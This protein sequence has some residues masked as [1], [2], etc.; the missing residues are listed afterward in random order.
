MY[1]TNKYK[2]E[3]FFNPQI[4]QIARITLIIVKDVAKSIGFNS[5]KNTR[6]KSIQYVVDIWSTDPLYIVLYN[7]RY[8]CVRLNKNSDPLTIKASILY[9]LGQVSHGYGS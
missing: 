5:Y 7:G 8:H 9:S 2:L 3:H 4:S 6:K 1:C